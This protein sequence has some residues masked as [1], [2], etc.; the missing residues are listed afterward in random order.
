MQTVFANFFVTAGH[1]GLGSIL[2]IASGILNIILDYIFIVILDMGISGAAFGTGFGYLMPTVFGLCFFMIH[3]N[4]TLHFCKTK[5]KMN[6]IMESC[7]NGS[8]EMVSQLAMAVTVFLFN[9][10]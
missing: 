1:P 10:N 6:V 5:W 2:S 8:S 7:L 4:E 3:R 9:L